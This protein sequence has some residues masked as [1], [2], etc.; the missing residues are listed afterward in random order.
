MKTFTDP[1][2]SSILTKMR[3]SGGCKLTAREWPAMRATDISEPSAAEQQHRLRSTELWYQ[4]GFTWAIVA[5]AQVIRGRLSATRA[6]ATLY[7]I[8]AQD[9]VL[10]HQGIARLSNDHIAEHIPV[11]HPRRS[12]LPPDQHAHTAAKR[13]NRSLPPGLPPGSTGLDGRWSNDARVRLS[14]ELRVSLSWSCMHSIA[15]SNRS[16]SDQHSGTQD[17]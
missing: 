10:N 9:Y 11:R 15:R 12:G 1:T 7:L 6:G 13:R 4:P 3:T 14:S 5:M 8:P 17:S 2:L 16:I